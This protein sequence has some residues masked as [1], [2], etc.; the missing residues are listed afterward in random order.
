MRQRQFCFSR[1]S[2]NVFLI[3]LLALGA[4]VRS[5]G[6]SLDDRPSAALREAWDAA[7]DPGLML[8]RPLKLSELNSPEASA[9]EVVQPWS[10]SYWPLDMAGI[11][12]RWIDETSVPPFEIAGDPESE[13]ENA[14]FSLAHDSIEASIDRS[15]QLRSQGAM[16]TWALSPAEKYD[17]IAG[18]DDFSLTRSELNSYVRNRRTYEKRGISWGWMG[19]CHGWA[20]ASVGITRPQNSLL[21]RNQRTGEEVFFSVGDVRALLTKI[22]SDNGS[23]SG[24]RF[25]GTRCEDK[26]GDIPRDRNFRIVDAALGLW[27]AEAESLQSDSRRS[28]RAVY[29]SRFDGGAEAEYPYAILEMLPEDSAR[30]ARAG[31]LIWVQG[32]SWIDYQHKVASPLI[33]SI[34]KDAENRLMPDLILW[35]QNI[36]WIGRRLDGQGE[37]VRDSSGAVLSDVETAKRI[38]TAAVGAELSAA[39]MQNPGIFG[40]KSYKECRD[41]NPATFHSA[42]VHWLSDRPGGL[43]RGFVMDRARTEQVWNHGI[44][45]FQSRFGSL[46]PLRLTTDGGGVIEDPLGAVRASGAQGIVDVETEVAFGVETGPRIFFNLDDEASASTTF[47][48]T[49]EFDAAGNLIGGEW[50]RPGYDGPLSGA[51]LLLDLQAEAGQR[52]A[53]WDQAPDFIWANA[54]KVVR[55]RDSNVMRASIVETLVECSTRGGQSDGTFAWPADSGGMVS[56]PYFSCRVE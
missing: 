13:D 56:V 33:F 55:F 9:G 29:H 15:R 14:Y 47:R 22:A 18:N 53:Y 19:H 2:V 35:A 28:F 37:W 40:F 32:Y 42:L 38:L 31:E 26:E 52:N 30:D 11:A 48:Y 1:P 44:W 45:R 25:S 51:E 34:R 50:H 36:D 4:C 3:V 17:I 27:G 49:L 12:R 41:I 21:V 6:Q 24:S 23:R 16:A 7:N 39:A 43:K 10:D 46:T 5:T 8:S 20:V 54:D